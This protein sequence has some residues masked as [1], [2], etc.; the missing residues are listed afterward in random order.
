MRQRSAPLEAAEDGTDDY[1]DED[2]FAIW[3]AQQHQEETRRFS[4]SFESEAETERKSSIIIPRNPPITYPFE[5]LGEYT[6]DNVKLSPRSC[7]ELR[8][9]DFLKIVHIVR[10]TSTSE[11]TIRGYIYRRTRE[12]NGLLDRK[13]NE[14][15]WILHVDDDD[16]RE[17]LIQGVETRAVSE[18]IRRRNIRLTNMTFPALSFRDEVGET[19]EVVTNYRVLVCRY[20]YLCL[21]PNTKARSMYAWCEKGLHRIRAGE[22]DGRSD[23]NMADHDLRHA[24]RGDT[25][26]GG[27]QEGWLNGEKEF[28]RQEAI[29]HKG[30]VSRQSLKVPN[31]MDFP[32]GDPMK[33]GV[34]GS[35]LCQSDLSWELPASAGPA[36][37]HSTFNVKNLQSKETAW[38]SDDLGEL[39]SPYVHAVQHRPGPRP[40]RSPLSAFNR[41]AM[42]ANEYDLAKVT[43]SIDLS[44]TLRESAI[45]T[46]KARH[47]TPQIVEINAQVKTSTSAGT[48]MKRYE[49]KITSSFVPRPSSK[50][51]RSDTL[52]D[53]P[54][55]PRVEIRDYSRATSPSDSDEIIGHSQSEA[56]V[57]ELRAPPKSGGSIATKFRLLTPLSLGSNDAIRLSIYTSHR[58]S[59]L[60][61]NLNLNHNVDVDDV[62]DLTAAPAHT[63][64]RFQSELRQPPMPGLV[65]SRSNAPQKHFKASP[66]ILAHTM[67]ARTMPAC[68]LS[69]RTMPA[70]QPYGSPK[71]KWR[72]YT[73]GDC[74]C[75]AGGM[76]RGA[77]NAGLRIN[78]GFDFNQVACLTYATN[79]FGTPVYQAWA[80]EF[81]NDKGDHKCDVCHLSPP[82]QF[83]SDAHTTQGKDDDMNTASLFAIFHLLEKAKPRV[84]T[85]EQT[86]GLIR[87]HP[88]FFN[89][90]IN[91][92]TSRGFSVRWRVMNC[93]DFGVP[94]RRLR[95]FIIA[96]W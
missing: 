40:H 8:D 28:L 89:A 54:R 3:I 61:R 78:W 92:F 16:P 29:S 73:F 68:T 6:Y 31:G 82:C 37:I 83:W 52:S 43:G 87:R 50:R 10:D 9:G 5:S 21:Y 7:V 33:R 57:Q 1:M 23:N 91:M 19:E 75:G 42:D 4:A 76:S 77:I 38:A 85:L 86:S 46:P 80:N 81:A 70:R 20:K 79:F 17:P 39:V 71:A 12:M 15:C 64:S 90:V 26:P 69:A 51:K 34:V 13:L 18:V 67:P 62:I 45:K 14:V 58:E 32:V 60:R 59:M 49:S 63:S 93:A 48:S 74:F 27:T 47:K 36:N 84:V 41:L 94:Q 95:L 2:Q 72:R 66:H 25:Q 88:L 53:Q 35:I 56:F 55:C 96:S 22:C 24:W 44:N 30:V 11:I 65:D